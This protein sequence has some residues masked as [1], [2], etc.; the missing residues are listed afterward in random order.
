MSGVGRYISV[1]GGVHQHPPKEN[2]HFFLKQNM[3]E[4]NFKYF[5]IFFFLKLKYK[6][7]PT[8]HS[9]FFEGLRVSIPSQYIV[10]NLQENRRSYTVKKNHIDSAVSK[11]KCVTATRNDYSII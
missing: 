10:I 5:L 4:G 9:I 8:T 11:I 2:R 6:V 3:E 7:S 1:F